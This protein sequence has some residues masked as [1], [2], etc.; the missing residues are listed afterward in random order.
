MMND[1]EIIRVLGK[2]SYGKV[3][4][5]R[6]KSDDLDCV[7]KVVPLETLTEEEKIV[8]LNE[9]TKSGTCHS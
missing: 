2:G 8:A 7:L 3:F 9:V 4:Q 5:A 6:R 1:F